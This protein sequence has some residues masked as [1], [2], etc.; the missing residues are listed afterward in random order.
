[1]KWN[2]TK[3]FLFFIFAFLGIFISVF[4]MN[5]T[6]ER[7]G[8]TGIV[9]A[10]TIHSFQNEINQYKLRNEEL[11]QKVD[12]LQSRLDSYQV[13]EPDYDALENELYN[14]LSKY[15]IITG[16]LDVAGQGVRIE[17]ADSTRILEPGENINNFIIHNSDVLEIINE[18]KTNGA[19]IIAINGYRLTWDSK[20][21]CAG[22]V[23]YV[24]D[25]VAGTPFIIEAIG[26]KEKL[27]AGLESQ[28]SIV[29][30]LRHWDIMVKVAE[31][32]RI[33]IASRDN[34]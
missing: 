24:D 16:K 23:I 20:I 13:E 22:P 10:K 19:E 2:R 25:F 21:D 7:E 8:W 17:L 11:E 31:K 9:T 33:V 28:D 3:F 1:M 29:Q 32:D 27:Y 14:E 30:L 6:R 26:D 15:D 5:T 12:E 4:F 18:L 34:L